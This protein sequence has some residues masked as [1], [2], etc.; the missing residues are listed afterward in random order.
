VPPGKKWLV[1]YRRKLPFIAS[2]VIKEDED[3]IKKKINKIIEEVRPAINDISDRIEKNFV[4]T[5]E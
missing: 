1:L 5:K 3:E 2:E 4:K